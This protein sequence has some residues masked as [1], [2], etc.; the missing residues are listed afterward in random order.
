MDE[1]QREGVTEMAP[2]IPSNSG[3]MVG[4]ELEAMLG[5]AQMLMASGLVPSRFKNP[6]AVAITAMYG[7]A[8]GLDFAT[9]IAEVYVVNGIPSAS[10]KMQMGVVKHREPECQI[11]IIEQTDTIC[12]IT[13]KRKHDDEPQAYQWTI[14]E[15]KQANLLHKDNWKKHPADMLTARC[16]TRGFRSSCMDLLGGFGYAPDELEESRPTFDPTKIKKAIPKKAPE[17]VKIEVV[18][19]EVVKDQQALK[20]LVKELEAT[21]QTSLAEM[22]YDE[23]RDKHSEEPETLVE[24]YDV[25][26]KRM[27]ELE[28]DKP[29]EAKDVD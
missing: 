22:I 10:A 27:K 1:G 3:L 25:F 15:A 11:K 2:A 7:R 16:L 8:L 12:K 26:Q 6:E 21:D 13:I 5:N 9:S 24:A 20:G 19:P 23:F 18:K 17:A 4:P 29:E 14:E 28:G